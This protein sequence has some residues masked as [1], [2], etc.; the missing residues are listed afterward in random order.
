MGK[1]IIII[2][3][4]VAG[5]SA[6][7]Y[8]QRSGFD[9]EII[10]MH[11]IPGGQCTAWDKKGYRFDYCLHW[12]VGTAKGP[13]HEIW[14]ETGV[15]NDQVEIYDHD[16][17]TRIVGQDGSDFIIYTNLDRWE[18]YLLDMAPEDAKPIRKMC[19]EMRKGTS[20]E[21]FLN[22]PEL[23]K[24]GEYMKIL[25]KMWPAFRMILQYGRKSARD[26]FR[27]RNFKNPKLVFYLDSIFGEH[28]F[29]A[30]AFLLMLAWF[31]Q[32]NAGYLIGGSGPFAKRMADRY[33]S[34]GGTLSLGKKVQTICVTDSKACGVTLT[35][36]TVSPGDY[37]ISAADGH[38]TLYSMLGGRFLPKP[39]KHAYE[40]W[41]LFTPLVQ[42][43]FGI[44]KPV[45][46]T[47]PVQ[48]ILA[49]GKTIGSTILENNYVLMNYCFDP[50]MAPEGKTV[51]VLRYESPW[52]IWKKMDG[53]S[54]KVEKDRIREDSICLLEKNHPGITEFIEVVDVATP[55]T[56]VR[57]TGVWE[58]SYEGFMPSAK[59][60]GKSL[61][62]T[63][64]GLDHFYMAGQWIYPGGGLPPSAQ[65]GKWAIQL[66]S[67]KEMR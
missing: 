54:Y 44:A 62:M 31:N 36:G 14:K 24:P 21:P 35:D 51:I 48:S 10:E 60:F 25:R 42:I 30:L 56:N 52:E 15:L 28:D 49:K 39:V 61:K 53:E 19:N 2:G 47:F 67:Q 29:S 7:I 9:T 66:I 45:P 18:A 17:H 4:G 20:L 50:T 8:G 63:L 34:L 27:K 33:L 40:S 5:L 46:A 41:T 23:R 59:N 55:R 37:V 65:S 26:Y 58:G 32:R 1:K 64:P 22:P 3:G 57:Y 43:S 12:L 16:V 13:F 11:T 6:G 38:S